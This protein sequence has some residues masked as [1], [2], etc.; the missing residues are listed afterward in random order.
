MTDHGFTKIVMARE[1]RYEQQDKTRQPL[2]KI[3]DFCPEHNFCNP[4][5]KDWS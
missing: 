4:F 3:E 5:S 1:N 2:L